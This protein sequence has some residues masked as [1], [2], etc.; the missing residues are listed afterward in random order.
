MTLVTCEVKL[1]VNLKTRPSD[2]TRS[3]KLGAM[4]FK[5]ADKRIRDKT[6]IISE[7]WHSKR[8]ADII[9]AY[10][11]YLPEISEAETNISRHHKDQISLA[12]MSYHLFHEFH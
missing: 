5:R 12:Q 2:I 11:I 6:R 7:Y 9:R 1:H 8:P 3:S 10:C 4:T